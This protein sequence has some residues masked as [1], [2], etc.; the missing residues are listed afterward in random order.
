[1]LHVCFKRERKV[2]SYPLGNNESSWFDLSERRLPDLA[3]SA[4]RSA[5]MTVPGTSPIAIGAAL[6]C[7]GFAFRR[8]GSQVDLAG[9]DGP[10]EFRTILDTLHEEDRRDEL[11]DPAAARGPWL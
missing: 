3:Q 7:V 4:C 9:P 10:D 11:F 8:G 5:Q 2:C 6:I 1:M